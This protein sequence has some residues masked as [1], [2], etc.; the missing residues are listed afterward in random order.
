[1]H[2]LLTDRMTC[3]RC[4]PEF[5]LILLAREVRERRIYHG[6]FGCSNCREQYPV[7]KGFGDLRTPPRSPL[8]PPS[9]EEWEGH[10]PGGPDQDAD[11]GLRLAALMGITEGPGTL[12]LVGPAAL[13]AS[14]VARLVTGVEVVGLHP[15]LQAM[16]QEEG[17]SRMV[18]RPGIPFFSGTFLGV[19]YSGAFD[20]RMLL[21]SVRVT[22]PFGRIAVLDSTPDARAPLESQRLQILLEEKGVLVAQRGRDTTEPAFVTLRGP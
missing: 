20:E 1:M 11:A 17:V 16:P 6:D 13:Q 4:G 2:L 8:S 15:A 14:A 21:E 5:G 9:Q 22:A 10:G 19:V 12:L 7:E 18:S 3:P